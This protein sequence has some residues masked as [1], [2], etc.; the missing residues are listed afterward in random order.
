MSGEISPTGK[1]SGPGSSPEMRASHADR[2][3]VVDVLRIAAGDGLLTA[4]E[5]DERLEAAL[6]ART[7]SELTTLT[8]DLPPVSATAG[9]PG[10]EV[11]DIV[12][13]EQVHSGAIE[14]VG[15]WV[16][17]RRL[18]LA[19]TFCEV[20]LD[21]TDAV[22]THDTLRIDVGMTGKTL[23]LVTRP[24]IV[25]DTDGLQLVHCK[26]KYRQTL[27]D[28]DTPVTLR[29]ELVGQKVHGRVVVRPRR[30][31]FGQWLLRRPTSLSAGA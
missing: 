15:R 11:K 9:V 6:S 23:T 29:V 8:A 4:D 22:I 31:T 26:V 3:R 12:R 10:A 21:F 16:V 20:T 28:P 14:R 19:V 7:L 27:T 13:I 24:G 18:E 5:L 30:R 17:P 25:V 2:D 1:R